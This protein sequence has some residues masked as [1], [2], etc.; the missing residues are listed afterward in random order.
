MVTN[1]LPLQ[2]MLKQRF[3]KI[4]KYKYQIIKNSEGDYV[5]FKMLSS[6]VS[7]VVSHLDEIRQHTK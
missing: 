3:G 2:N 6:N 1:C 5:T 7:D 4:P